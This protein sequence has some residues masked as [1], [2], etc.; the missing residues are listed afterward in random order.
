MQLRSHVAMA[1]AADGTG[2]S[3]L[4]PSLGTSVCLKCS[5]KKQKKKK[6]KKSNP[7]VTRREQLPKTSKAEQRKRRQLRYRKNNP[8][9]PAAFSCLVRMASVLSAVTGTFSSPFYR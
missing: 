2:S 9:C 7:L 8:S 5:P 1:V 3:D 6:K 4:T